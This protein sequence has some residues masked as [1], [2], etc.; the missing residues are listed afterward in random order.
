MIFT[1]RCPNRVS[2]IGG[3]SDTDWFVQK[4]GYGC[5]LGFSINKYSYI[6]LMQRHS[7]EKKGILNYSAREEYIRTETI[8]HPLIRGVLEE[9][10]F[11]DPLEISSFGVPKGG[12]GLGGSSSFLVA[13]V[14]A[15]NMLKGKSIQK[16]ELA[17]IAC[18]IEIGRLKRVIGRQ[19]QYLCALGGMNFLRFGANGNV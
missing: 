13:L 1:A 8:S 2:L 14:A 12:Q 3:G 19:D 5:S 6:S 7:S 18:N 16:A 11:D 17:N 9:Y 4:H 10:K 15:I